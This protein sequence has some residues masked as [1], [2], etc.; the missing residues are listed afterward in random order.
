MILG[1]KS[2]QK[3]SERANMCPGRQK[4]PYPAHGKTPPREK[5]HLRVGHPPALPHTEGW[6]PDGGDRAPPSCSKAQVQRK[7]ASVHGNTHILVRRPVST[8][9]P[10]TWDKKS[11]LQV[12][13][14]AFRVALPADGRAG[15]EAPP[16]CPLYPGSGVGVG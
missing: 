9:C 8:S 16:S 12:L 14:P 10:S 6:G 3:L 2:P 7:G 11:L 5:A 13:L 1:Y 15:E 4:K